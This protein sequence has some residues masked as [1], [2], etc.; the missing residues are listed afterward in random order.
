MK[1][2]SLPDCEYSPA[3]TI[4]I[5]DTASLLNTIYKLFML[6]KFY[7][8]HPCATCPYLTIQFSYAEAF[9]FCS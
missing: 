8:L 2:N 9:S 3:F 6:Q 5:I 7:V 1:L 4:L